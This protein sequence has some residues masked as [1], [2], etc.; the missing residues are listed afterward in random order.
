MCDCVF[1]CSM[2]DV[3]RRWN[4]LYDVLWSNIMYSAVLW[5]TLRYHDVL[6]G[7]LLY[8]DVLRY[9]MM[10]YAVLCHGVLWC[11]LLCYEVLWCAMVCSG[12]WSNCLIIKDLLLCDCAV[13]ILHRQVS[14]GFS[15]VFFAYSRWNWI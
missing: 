4:V 1:R 13:D 2:L 14:P 3:L 8:Y 15:L 5:C 7:V 9:D 11:V 12:L 10:C 6:R